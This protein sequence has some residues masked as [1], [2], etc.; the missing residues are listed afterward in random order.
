MVPMAVQQGLHTFKGRKMEVYNMEI[1][2]LRQATELLNGALSA[3]NLPAAIEDVGGSNKLPQS[4]IDKAQLIKDRG[5]I[6]RI[7]SMMADL[8]PLLARNTE[9]LDEAQRT[10]D[11]EAASDTELR[12]NMR[13]RWSRTPSAQLNNSLYREIQE[14]RNIIAKAVAANNTVETK[15]KNNRDGIQLL[16]KPVSEINASLPMASS[17]AALQNS[18]AVKEIR[19]V[20]DQLD[21]LKNVR[22]VLESEMKTSDSD[23]LTARLVSAMQTSTSMD[24]H[25]I[26]TQE[27]EAAVSFNL[28]LLDLSETQ[29]KTF[30]VFLDCQP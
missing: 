3:L 13:E 11:E 10:L 2:K 7:D 29:T 28:L 6:T 27:L 4:I 24:Q 5:G 8:P 9:I 1:G 30:F 19:R 14:F 12:N 26:I 15:Y 23:A 21:G 17:V 20:L 25:A 22:D 16:S 18:F